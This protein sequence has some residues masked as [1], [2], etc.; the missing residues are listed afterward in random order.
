MSSTNE[1]PQPGARRRILLPDVCDQFGVRFH[2]TFAM[3]RSLQVRYD[4]ARES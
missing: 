1:Q 4:F 3:L 2:N